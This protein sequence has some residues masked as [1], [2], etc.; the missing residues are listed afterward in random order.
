MNSTNNSQNGPGVTYSPRE[1]TRTFRATVT[2]TT[3][4]GRFEEMLD[5]VGLI[6]DAFE[7]VLKPTKIAY[8]IV[9]R[10][11]SREFELES[12]RGIEFDRFE[13]A[14][15]SACSSDACHLT[16]VSISGAAWLR[17]ADGDY[18][19][20]IESD[21]Y[22]SPRQSDQQP[23][24]PPIELSL[25]QNDVFVEEY[26]HVID[27]H[28]NTDIFTKDSL[29]G[30]VNRRRLGTALGRV[31]DELD[32]FETRLESDRHTEAGFKNRGFDDLIFEA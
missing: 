11:T 1:F 31:Y 16:P 28:V 14:V 18:W 19:V 20:D 26:E 24:R 21:R 12:E 23:S 2:G 13:I 8:T 27:I 7:R 6:F 3:D 4:A 32:V 9:D 30:E 22:Q 17:L 15:R 25:S 29:A 5:V 10:E